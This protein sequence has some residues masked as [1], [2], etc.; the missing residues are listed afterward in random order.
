LFGDGDKY[1]KIAQYMTM[2]NPDPSDI[3][4]PKK[5]AVYLTYV[6]CWADES[7]TLQ[8]RPDVYGLDIVLFG[9][10]NKFLTA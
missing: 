2:D 5:T 7:G 6:T 3:Q 4:L 8:F 9:H 10:L 1:D